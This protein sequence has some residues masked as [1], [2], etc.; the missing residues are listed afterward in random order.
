MKVLVKCQRIAVLEGALTLPKGVIYVDEK[1]EPVLAKNVTELLAKF[2]NDIEKY[3]GELP[4]IDVRGSRAKAE[5]E[6]PAEP[7]PE[8]PKKEEA[9]AEEKPA[10]RG[11]RSRA[12]A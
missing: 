1:E 10:P 12:E 4:G 5:A 11:R 7:A 3:E 8:E 6:K 9:S 2:P